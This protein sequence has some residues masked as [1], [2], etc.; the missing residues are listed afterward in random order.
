MW[1]TA[2]TRHASA[3]LT[4]ESSLVG[5]LDVDKFGSR[6]TTAGNTAGG[7]MFPTASASAQRPPPFHADSP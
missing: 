5:T 1:A 7:E 3:S 6:V 2:G 4:G